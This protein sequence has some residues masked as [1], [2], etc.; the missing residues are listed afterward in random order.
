[1]G[2][3]FA[4]FLVVFGLAGPAIVGPVS[5]SWAGAALGADPFLFSALGCTLGG[6]SLVAFLAAAAILVARG[7]AS[8]WWRHAVIAGAVL[9]GVLT[10]LAATAAAGIVLAVDVALAVLAAAFATTPGRRAAGAA[11]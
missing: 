6:L 1:M 8:R 5:E 9:S 3:R 11:S 2:K 10:V 7:A 4:A